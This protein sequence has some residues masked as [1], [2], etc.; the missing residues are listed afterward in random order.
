[1]VGQVQNDKRDVRR[2][3]GG[4][5]SLPATGQLRALPLTAGDVGVIHPP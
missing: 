1:M 4:I 3:T 5:C 2:L